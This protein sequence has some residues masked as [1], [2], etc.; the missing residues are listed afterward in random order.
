MSLSV[1]SPAGTVPTAH[2]A[3]AW[4]NAGNGLYAARTGLDPEAAKNAVSITELYAKAMEEA[5]QRQQPEITE[6]IVAD[7][8]S[9]RYYPDTGDEAA[10]RKA[11][12]AID[13]Y[14]SCFDFTNSRDYEKLTAEEDFTGMTRAEKYAAIYEKYQHCY[15]ENFL[16]GKAAD[17]SHFPSEYD[18]WRP[19]LNRFDDEVTAACGG[20]KGAA[21]ARREALYG[22][23]GS[24]YEVREAIIDKYMKDST[25][26]RLTH[27]NYFKMVS[28]MD[29][30]GVGGGISASLDQW[31]YFPQNYFDYLNYGNPRANN[32]SAEYLDSYITAGDIEDIRNSY[33]Y[34]EI[35]GCGNGDYPA[36]LSQITSRITADKNYT[37]RNNIN[38]LLAV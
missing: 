37:L 6:Y 27:R 11:K 14:N 18:F 22:D 30:C 32:S 5:S 28:E 25:D 31:T 16:D 36:A 2:A 29:N 19:V 3:V 1:S 38:R 7:F 15:G 34:M 9:L 33:R 35:S 12:E 23:C 17:L 20:A 13:Y 24:D 10:D 21:E 4:E 26:G 8:S